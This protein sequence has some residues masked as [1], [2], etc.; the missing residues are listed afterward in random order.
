VLDRLTAAD[1][2]PLVGSGFAAA[3]PGREELRLEL[4]EV[5]RLREPPARPGRP[6][7]R[8]PFALTFRGRTP[9]YVPQGTYPITHDR[10]GRLDVFL[11]PVGRDDNGLL[12]EAVFA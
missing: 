7:R 3:L 4:T 10:L 11:V 9:D 8:P 5:R 12:L 6:P 2:E 1:F